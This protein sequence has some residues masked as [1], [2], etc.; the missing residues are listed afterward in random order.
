MAIYHLEAKVVS[1]GTGRSAVAAAADL[2]CT[3]I[4]N[5]Y[6]GIRHD[7]TRKKGLVWREVFLPEYAPPEWKDRGVLWNA[8]EENEKTKDSRLAREFVPALPIE[9]TP[10]Q[11]QDLL[12]DFIQTSFVSEGMCAD[13]AIHDPHPPGHNPHAHIMLTVRPLDE[14]GN[15]QYKT[16]KE[17][18]CIKDGEE[19]GFT[20]SE[21]KMAQA[22]G[23]EKQYPYKVGKK[24]VYMPPSEAEKQGLERAS[25]HPKS[26]K[27]GRQNHI[28]E[29]WNSEEQLVLWRKAWADVTNRY[30]E[31]YGHDARIDHRSHTERGLAEQP[32]IHEGVVARALEKKGIISD[33]CELNRQIK[34]D[35]AMLRELKATVKKL[36]QAVKN[37][38][39]AIAK[40][41]ESVRQ[42]V[43][44]FCYQLGHIRTGQRKL[45]TYI[46]DVKAEMKQYSSLV[47]Q[48]KE[49]SRERKSLLAEQKELPFWNVPRKKELTARIAELTELLE[50][51]KS[52][53]AIVLQHLQCADDSNLSDV[54]KEIAK[55]EAGLK[56]LEEQEMKYAAELDN[57]LKQYA[58]L[59]E[60][61]ADFEPLDLHQA[62]QEIRSDKEQSAIRRVQNT[63]GNA[64]NSMTMF[65]AKHETANLLGEEAESHSLRERLRQKEQQARQE[66]QPKKN[67]NRDWER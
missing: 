16:E 28:A 27:F 50:E 22:D 67:K 37:T 18:L 62:R 5:D 12:S 55:S 60:Q 19:K 58:E 43:L 57:A 45:K 7:Y 35:N 56:K 51:L 26:T 36:M 33:R 23:W 65:D 44:I 32:T 38:I 13:V 40:A 8:V 6:D 3:N 66:R 17:Y 4:L 20:A 64:Y 41:M 54:K 11:W 47:E 15:W 30:L 49:K 1:R 48:I 63:Y 52:E 25:K 10:E 9:L 14:Q 2:S 53:K 21:F 59:Q 24:K 39:P 61:A 42:N 29:R 34:A 46:S 31:Q